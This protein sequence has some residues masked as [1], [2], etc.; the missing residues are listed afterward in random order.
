MLLRQPDLIEDK[1]LEKVFDR[2]FKVTPR[3]TATTLNKKTKFPRTYS[4]TLKLV[5]DARAHSTKE[6]VV[7]AGTEKTEKRSDVKLEDA[8]GKPRKKMELTKY[9]SEVD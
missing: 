4:G 7:N 5:A 6:V 2:T 9:A 8:M 3:E 1:L